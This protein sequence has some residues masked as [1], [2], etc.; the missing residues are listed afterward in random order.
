MRITILCSDINHPVID[1]LNKWIESN[2][3]DNEIDLIYD[4]SDISNGD[5]LFLISCHE[6]IPKTIRDCYKKTLLIHASDL[7]K[8]KGWSPHVWDIINGSDKI[9]L[10]LLKA[11]DK[12]D[13]GEVYK[14]THIKIENHELWNEINHKLFTAEI[15]LIN[16]AVN[17]FDKLQ[18]V[19]QK[20]DQ[21]STFYSK[22]SPKDSKINP[23]ISIKDQFNKIR[24]MDPVRYPAFFELNGHKYKLRI[25]KINE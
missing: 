12:I 19:E 1:Y 13:S 5:I 8:G 2:S 16:Y 18:G 23:N 24:V 14:K 4:K 25:N 17:S 6:I 22:R 7:P 21:N 10:S 15:D 11:E 9:T 20:K 3:L